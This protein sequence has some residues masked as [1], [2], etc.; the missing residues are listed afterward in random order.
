MLYIAKLLLRK[1][2]LFNTQRYHF[3]GQCS[4][5]T[6]RQIRCHTKHDKTCHSMP[7]HSPFPPTKKPP[8]TPL[9]SF[10]VKIIPGYTAPVQPNLT[11]RFCKS[12]VALILHLTRVITWMRESKLVQKGGSVDAAAQ[13]CQAI[14]L[15]S[16]K[17][18]KLH[19]AGV[20]T[21]PLSPEKDARESHHWKTLP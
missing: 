7:T 13:F 14:L 20:N 8:L 19:A 3:L 17:T 5:R 6:T 16:T 10:H 4:S 2:W 11:L 9:R 12:I 21:P 18:G 15:L 1:R